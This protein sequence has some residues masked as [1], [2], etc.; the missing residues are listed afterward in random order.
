MFYQDF[1]KRE[2]SKIQRRLCPI[3]C[4]VLKRVRLILKYFWGGNEILK[5]RVLG[6]RFPKTVATPD[7][8]RYNWIDEILDPSEF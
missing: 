6:M 7:L 8:G 3:F 2:L 5:M 1:Y 4:K